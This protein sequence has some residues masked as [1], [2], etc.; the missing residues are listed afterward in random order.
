MPLTGTLPACDYLARVSNF[1]ERPEVDIWPLT[2]RQ[3]LPTLPIPLLHP[4]PPVMLDLGAALRTVYE[5]ARYNL[6]VDYS[7][8]L[9]PPLSEPD[10]SWVAALLG[11]RT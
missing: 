10:A 6:R 8:P 3:P 5:R 2:I 1:Y 7:K 11:S 9:A 4:D